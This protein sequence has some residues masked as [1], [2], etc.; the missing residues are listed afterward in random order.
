[1]TLLEYSYTN[2]YDFSQ[3]FIDKF[4]GSGQR[5]KSANECQIIAT[6]KQA[7]IFILTDFSDTNMDASCLYSD[8]SYSDA[9]FSNWISGL[10]QC[11]NSQ[12]VGSTE[13]GNPRPINSCYEISGN[14]Y[15]G[16]GDKLSIYYSPLLKVLLSPFPKYSVD[17]QL[18]DTLYKDAV[19]KLSDYFNNKTTY[20]E[21]YYHYV[22][23]SGNFSSDNTPE[24]NRLE[25]SKNRSQSVLQTNLSLISIEYK[26]L[27]DTVKKFNM[28]Y[29]NYI[30]ESHRVLENINDKILLA[31][32]FFNSVRN[33]NQGAIGEL[34]I[35]NYNLS[36]SIFN[37]LVVSIVIIT[38]IYIY[39]KKAE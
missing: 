34:D 22:D 10:N 14:Q 16:K 4:T 31:N 33:K 24:Y 38:A 8:F 1:M 13:E 21:Y 30:N 19:K 11:N 7:S 27:L 37:N 3:N 17:I 26:V 5:V 15:F 20:L 36:L 35:N 23:S 2:T 29:K 6:A 9:S 28:E 12:T 39:L 18:F 32:N 25:K